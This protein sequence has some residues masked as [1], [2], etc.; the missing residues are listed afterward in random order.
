LNST[1]RSGQRTDLG[2]EE[3]KKH[4]PEKAQQ[5]IA[6][7]LGKRSTSPFACVVPSSVVEDILAPLARTDDPPATTRATAAAEFDD[8]Y[9]SAANDDD[10]G[11]I[12]DVALPIVVER[13]FPLLHFDDLDDLDDLDDRMEVWPP[14]PRAA[15]P[16]SRT[17]RFKESHLVRY[18]AT[19]LRRG[20]SFAL[21]ADI[22]RVNRVDLEIGWRSSTPT[23]HEVSYKARKLNGVYY[24]CLSKILQ[25]SWAYSI[26]CDAGDDGQGEDFLGLRVR[27]H[28]RGTMRDLH[29]SAVAMSESHTGEYMYELIDRTMR[30]L[31]PDWNAKVI[32]VST[33]GASSMTGCI[34]GFET[35]VAKSIESSPT[36]YRVQCV[37][38]RANLALGEAIRSFT[39]DAHGLKTLDGCIVYHDLDVM[40]ILCGVVRSIRLAKSLQKKTRKQCPLYIKVRWESLAGV[41]HWLD[42]HYDTLDNARRRLVLD[43]LESNSMGLDTDGMVP[44]WIVVRCLND[45]MQQF[46]ETLKTVQARSF[47]VADTCIA[48]T[49]VCEKLESQ[50]NIVSKSPPGSAAPTGDLQHGAAS[51][52]MWVVHDVIQCALS[53]A[54]ENLLSVPF[55][56]LDIYVMA[57]WRQATVGLHTSCRFVLNLV[58][59]L[60]RHVAEACD[61]THY[62]S[63]PSTLPLP[64]TNTVDAEF[65]SLVVDHEQRLQVTHKSNVEVT[66][67]AIWRQRHTLKVRV[68]AENSLMSRLKDAEIMGYDAAW[69]PVAHMY[70]ELAEFCRG[71]GTVMPTTAAVESDVS[72]L[73]LDHSPSRSS[74]TKFGIQSHLNN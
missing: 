74:L 68:G 45:V 73:K 34:R 4:F 43:H 1:P 14:N 51:P 3:K 46:K 36:T 18:T 20:G 37:A 56:A 29:V 30:A 38:H 62:A 7:L 66:K 12:I 10:E 52:D 26:G 6:S 60:R 42:I 57:T 39:D 48:F 23:R 63:P 25:D 53:S 11:R 33:D 70:P 49:S 17:T 28:C 2:S 40:K 8:D 50:F 67:S 59:A 5:F 32:G 9:M 41:F 21:A 35:L 55:S 58:A 44:F 64:I 54:K 65:R 22:M 19:I 47:S 61:R 27:V 15:A 16:G 13:L 71:I 72:L 69:E 31:D 24:T